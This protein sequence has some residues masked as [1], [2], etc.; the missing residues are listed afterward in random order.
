MDGIYN[1]QPVFVENI[2]VWLSKF[3]PSNCLTIPL[4][5]LIDIKKISQEN[6]NF[7]NM[8]KTNYDIYIS[9]RGQV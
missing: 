7:E 1:N 2:T 6:Y 9:G 3:F 5:N 4:L 8:R